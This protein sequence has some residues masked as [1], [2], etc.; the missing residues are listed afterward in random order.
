VINLFASEEKENF[1]AVCDSVAVIEFLL[2]RV[3][4]INLLTKSAVKRFTSL[5]H[6]ESTA[7]FT[8]NSADMAADCKLN[9]SS[10]K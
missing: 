7:N 4:I 6:S 10:Q 3:L 2:P 9:S 8:A 1:I 5:Q